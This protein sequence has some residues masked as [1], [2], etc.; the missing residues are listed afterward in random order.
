MTTYR[1]SFQ[2]YEYHELERNHPQKSDTLETALNGQ[3]KSWVISMNTSF[4]R[5]KKLSI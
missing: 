2:S 3:Y 1:T 4:H 5:H